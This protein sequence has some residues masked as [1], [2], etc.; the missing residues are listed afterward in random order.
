MKTFFELREEITATPAVAG[1]GDN[2]EKIVPVHL[3]KK[4][5][6]KPEVIDRMVKT[7]ETNLDE[8]SMSTRWKAGV[9]RAVRGPS[10]KAKPAWMRDTGKRAKQIAKRAQKTKDY[11]IGRKYQA[12]RPKLGQSGR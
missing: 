7:E 6:K 10:K 12:S 9:A 4:K 8:L 11:E 1:A 2:P 5:K 3:K